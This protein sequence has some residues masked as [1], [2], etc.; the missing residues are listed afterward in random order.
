M[1]ILIAYDGSEGA[2]AALDDLPKAGELRGGLTG[3]RGV[4]CGSLQVSAGTPSDGI[5]TLT[6][7]A[8]ADR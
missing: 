2:E 5:T 8:G 6:A 3:K 4:V 1:K 7:A